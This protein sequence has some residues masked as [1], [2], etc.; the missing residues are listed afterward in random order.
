MRLLKRI[1]YLQALVWAGAGVLFTFV[2]GLLLHDVFGQPEYVDYALVRINGIE[3]FVL[4]LLMV[5]VAHRIE[6]LWWW[7]WAFAF[8]AAGMAVVSVLNALFSVPEGAAIW[9]WWL[10]AGV[11][12]A[13]ALALAWG[14]ARAGQEK[15]VV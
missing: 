3:G 10:F 8:L 2:P 12:G 9:P 15:P 4:A 14:L 11:D 6:T 13:F 7:S 5:M 1:L